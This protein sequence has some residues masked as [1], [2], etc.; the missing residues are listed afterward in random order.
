MDYTVINQLQ[1]RADAEQVNTV[2][3]E[4]QG[5]CWRVETVR[6]RWFGLQTR[7]FPDKNR[8]VAFKTTSHVVLVIS[9]HF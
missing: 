5:T 6:K 9:K 4:A 2:G 7:R 1:R 3:Q 8:N